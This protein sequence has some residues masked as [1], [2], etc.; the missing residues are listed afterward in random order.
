MTRGISPHTETESQ[1]KAANARYS[2][3]ALASGILALIPA[4]FVVGLFLGFPVVS[5]DVKNHPWV[6]LPPFAAALIAIVFASIALV[7]AGPRR[8][9]GKSIAKTALFSS[10]LCGLVTL[11]IVPF[12][13][14]QQDS[15]GVKCGW[16]LRAI[17]KAMKAYQ[18]DCGEA[19]KSLQSLVDKGYVKD[20]GVFRCQD[21]LHWRSIDGRDVDASGD[22][23]YA[24]LKAGVNAPYDTPV[25]WDKT[26]HYYYRWASCVCVDGFTRV[27]GCRTPEGLA[28]ISANS[29]FYERPPRLPADNPDRCWIARLE[30]KL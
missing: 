13:V 17:G 19:P 20:L 29:A 14:A 7:A 9:R 23:Y 3:A 6:V 25:V 16:N 11:F 5:W 10:I 28:R 27:I 24:R 1:G 26:A 2:K 18:D 30:G 15:N 21:I 22:Y 12:E 8:L 4:V